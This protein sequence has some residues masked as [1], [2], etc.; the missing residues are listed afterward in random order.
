MQ[1]LETLFSLQG[2]VAI[3]TGGLGQLGAEYARALTRAGARVAV[4]DIRLPSDEERQH[5]CEACDI[6]YLETD[7]TKKEALVAGLRE[8]EERLGPP[9][10]LVNNAALDAPPHASAD[11]NGPFETYPL[12]AWERVMGVNLTGIFL[13]CQVIGGRMAEL[14]KGSIIN[15]SST[16]GMVSPNQGIYAYREARD[17]KP[18]FK[19]AVYSASKSGILNLTRYLATYWAKDGV[20]VNTLVP[21]GVFNG[22][23]EAFLENYQRLIPLGRMAKQNEFNGMVIYLASEASAYVTGATLVVDGGMTAW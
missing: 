10:I 17:G 22:Q 19:P 23:D 8:V 4:F 21:A 5:L 15:V 7:I 11:V 20:R 6:L 1:Y 14:G 18:F 9:S 16:Y 2:R 12:E 3:V 13:C